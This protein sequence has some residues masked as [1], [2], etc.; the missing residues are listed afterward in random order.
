M[1]EWHIYASGPSKEFLKNGK[2]VAKYWKGDGS[3]YG[4]KNVDKVL[5]SDLASYFFLLPIVP[6]NRFT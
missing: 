6:S 4:K 2:P 3:K 5:T 1:A